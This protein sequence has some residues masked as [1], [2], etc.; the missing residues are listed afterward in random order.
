MTHTQTKK[1][2]PYEK[3]PMVKQIMN[4]VEKIIK[5]KHRNLTPPTA[6][7]NKEQ[8]LLSDVMERCISN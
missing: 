3:L 5:L 7:N 6:S 2:Q 1:Y 8:I 4:T